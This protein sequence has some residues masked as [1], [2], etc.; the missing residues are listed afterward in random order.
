MQERVHLVHG[1]FFVESAPGQG[2]RIVATVP[3]VEEAT[4]ADEP[5]GLSGVA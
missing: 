3:L 5:A 2:T 1:T 4:A